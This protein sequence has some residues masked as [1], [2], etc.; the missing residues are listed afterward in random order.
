MPIA[1]INSADIFFLEKIIIDSF[2]Y[3]YNNY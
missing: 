2:S 3:K 1:K